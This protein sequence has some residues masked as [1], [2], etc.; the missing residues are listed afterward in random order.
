MKAEKKLK[1]Y[2]EDLTVP[3]KASIMSKIGINTDGNKVIYTRKASAGRRRVAVIMA[4][5]LAL[6]ILAVGVSAAGVA[7]H[8]NDVLLWL[9]GFE[10][11]TE[12]G[13]P[14]IYEEAKYRFT[15]ITFVEDGKLQDVSIDVDGEYAPSA[16]YNK[17]MELLG[18]GG[19]VTLVDEERIMIS[20]AKD[21][22]ETMGGETFVTHTPA[23]YARHIYLSGDKAPEELMLKILVNTSL[24]NMG[25]RYCMIYFNGEPMQIGESIPEHGYGKFD[26]KPLY[27]ATPDDHEIT[28]TNISIKVVDKD[29][30]PVPNVAVRVE[31]VS[32][33]KYSYINGY[34]MTNPTNDCVVTRRLC[35]GTTYNIYAE[36]RTSIAYGD[37]PSRALYTQKTEI[38]VLGDDKVTVVW[39]L[40]ESTIQAKKTAV[41]VLDKNGDPMKNVWVSLY[42]LDMSDQ[43]ILGY[44]DEQGKAYCYECPD[45]EYYVGAVTYDDG[46][47][48]SEWWHQNWSATF[49][50]KIE[51][52][53]DVTV[54]AEK[55]EIP[56]ATTPTDKETEPSEYSELIGRVLI[57]KS[58]TH[59]II[60]DNDDSWV[61][62][63]SP[64]VMH[65]T[66]G[67]SFEGLKTGD[68][69]KIG[70]EMIMET[71]P[72]ETYVQEL[73]FL[74]HGSFDDIPESAISGLLELG[75][76]ID[77][78]AS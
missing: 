21:E 8:G 78:L 68:R 20:P 75:W 77:D 5:I 4:A 44:T 41:T 70:V 53:A 14:D 2:C 6:L 11:D 9:S 50:V 23:V 15:C 32:G 57:T 66:D 47:D 43:M 63:G 25:D 28:T 65:T 55:D 72:G 60:I 27:E 59:L 35:V 31:Y 73:E 1:K 69:I 40:D 76:V 29:G 7:V 64:I 62:Y 26:L 52:G 10:E 54:Q 3:E 42:P 39:K 36:K 37:L 18:I 48:A 17:Q 24:V 12:T 51:N 38:T 19:E 45:G 58:G 71:Y 61:S 56:P 46:A 30:N 22:Y 33:Y 49:K 74:A 13:D 34:S 16:V 67:V